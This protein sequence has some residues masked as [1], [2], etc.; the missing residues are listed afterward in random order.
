M[1]YKRR[2]KLSCTFANNISQE[3]QN[4]VKFRGEEGKFKK[5]FYT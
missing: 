5:L 3:E 2:L 1:K 4:T